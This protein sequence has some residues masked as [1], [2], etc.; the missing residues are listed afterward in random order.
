MILFLV[1]CCSAFVVTVLCGLVLL[2]LRKSKMGIAAPS[3]DASGK[4]PP[5]ALDEIK[6]VSGLSD[7]QVDRIMQLIMIFEQSDTRWWLYYGYC[8]AL[9]YDYSKAWRGTTVSLYG[10]TTYNNNPGADAARLFKH[11]GKSITDLGWTSDKACCQL[12]GCKGEKLWTIRKTAGK[13]DD[14]SEAKDIHELNASC[15]FCKNLASLNDNSA[16]RAAV[17]KAFSAEYFLPAIA[18]LK[19]NGYPMK[20]A[21][22]G[23]AV[24]FALNEGKSGLLAGLKSAGKSLPALVAHRAKSGSCCNGSAANAKKRAELWNATITS[25][26]DLAHDVGPMAAKYKPE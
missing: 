21:I 3:S 25:N 18:E 12:P 11:Y 10:A 5:G 9:S 13:S 19:K 4:F 20:A 23:F 7:A 26:P 8:R 2:K 6:A 14:D 17:W 15:Q 1:S 22:I 16:W 24:D